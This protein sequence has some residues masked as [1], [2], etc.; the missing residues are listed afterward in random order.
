MET[1][2]EKIKEDKTTAVNG[3]KY[4]EAARL[5]DDEKRVEGLLQSEQKKWEDASKLNREVVS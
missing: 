4:E 3:Q 5:R 2:L 1:Q